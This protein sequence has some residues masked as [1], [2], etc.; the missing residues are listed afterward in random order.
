VEGVRNPADITD[1]LA[2]QLDMLG[3]AT[4]SRAI[5][6]TFYVSP[7]GDGTDGLSWAT[8]YQTIPDAVAVASAD[9][10][11]TTLL[12]LSPGEHDMNTT[13]DPNITKNVWLQGTH[14]NWTTIANNHAGAT[15][16]IGFT[17]FG[18]LENLT[19]DCGTGSNNGVAW[20]GGGADGAKMQSIYIEA[21][22]VTGAHD[23]IAFVG[24]VQYAHCNAVK[25]HGVKTLT[26]AMFLNNC[27]LS[28][29]RDIEFHDCLEGL[30]I[31]NAASDGNEFV[32]MLLHNCTLGL[33]INGGNGQVF[34]NVTFHG[35]TRNIDDEVGD[36]EWINIF[37][38]F[39]VILNPDNLVGINVACGAAG[40]YGA[41]T[42][43]IAA[44]A[45]DNPFRILGVVFAPS[46][47]P[48]EWYQVRF[49][50]DSGATYHDMMMFNADRRQG[51]SAPGGTEHIFNR[52]LRISASAR[53]VSGGNNV[54]VW[55]EIQEI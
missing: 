1:L 47:L 8:A 6:A 31:S 25:V 7:N 24:G 39:D 29:F 17:A 10:N 27:A 36:H 21:E 41:D 33:N 40:V 34:N 55:L 42:Q 3:P 52:G 46:A 26:T 51:V 43:L 53:S 44:G 22:H 13:G 54:D 15:L 14:R 38:D 49:S 32:D 2:R 12:L 30:E 35:C 28:N 4:M 5:T 23:A 9:A 16:V 50:H 19:I 45:L 18:A 11:A 20:G 37:G 48:A